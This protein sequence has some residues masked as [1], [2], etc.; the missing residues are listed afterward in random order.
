MFVVQQPVAAALRAELVA[1]LYASPLT[2]RYLKKLAI[3]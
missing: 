2:P 3:A 1:G